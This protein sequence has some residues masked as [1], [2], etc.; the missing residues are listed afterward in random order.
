V[1]EF[2]LRI[3]PRRIG[4]GPIRIALALC[5]VVGAS[6]LFWASRDYEVIA[7]DWDG[8]IRG[9]AY[10]PSHLF[11]E[12]D[13]EFVT[14]E[15]IDRD[16]AQIAQITSHVHTYTVGNGLDKV[17]EIAR[18]YG[19]TVSLG[20]WIGSDLEQN[21]KEIDLGI[22]TALANRRVVDRVFVGNEAILRGDVTSDQLNTYIK[23]VRSALPARI[24]IATAEP[25]STWLLTPEIGQYVDVVSVNLFPYWEGIPARDSLSFLQH[26]FQDVQ[27]EFP[28]KPIDSQ[29]SLYR[30]DALISRVAA[31]RPS[32][33]ATH[34][35]PWPVDPRPHAA[36]APTGLSGHGRPRCLGDDRPSRAY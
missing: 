10:N 24:K 9:I 7:P 1:P 19:L 30:F 12:K 27:D 17:P 16:L 36:R 29:I 13:R 33:R 6:V 20:L 4:G 31:L 32:R 22:K 11:R 2:L 3:L 8:Q 15:H 25:W 35:Y 26:A 18:R 23:R 34:A 5:L 14:P 21:E 28:D